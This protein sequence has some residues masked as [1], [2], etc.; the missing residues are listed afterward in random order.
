[1]SCICILKSGSRKG[2]KCGKK[3]KYGPFCGQHVNCETND[4][5]LHY[6]VFTI[7]YMRSADE[8]VTERDPSAAKLENYIAESRVIPE[9]IIYYDGYGDLN[10][11]SKV[12]YIGCRSFQ[13]ECQSQ[14]SL[15]KIAN[16]LLKQNLVDGEYESEP[17]NGSFVYPTKDGR[18]LGLLYFESV[19]VD[20]KKFER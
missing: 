20:G 8:T 16:L 13:F 15:S 11:T 2:K 12:E 19:E 5:F 17:G 10:L 18:E 14:L 9:N 1:M 3:A 7:G 4:E 6:V